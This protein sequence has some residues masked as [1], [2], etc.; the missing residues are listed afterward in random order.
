M[1]KKEDIVQ[2]KNPK[3]GKY[4]KIDRSAGTI[5]GHKKTKGPYKGIPIAEKRPERLKRPE[6]PTFEYG[7]MYKGKNY[8]SDY[9][10]ALK[11]YVRDLESYCDYLEER[12]LKERLK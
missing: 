2:I 10:R 1:A 8:A 11:L 7:W 6:S 5:I 12:D 3:S 4:I 9:E